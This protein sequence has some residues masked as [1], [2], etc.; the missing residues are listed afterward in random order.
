[1]LAAIR[2]A[3]SLLIPGTILT[4][5]IERET[6]QIVERYILQSKWGNA[7]MR[8]LWASSSLI[9]GQLMSTSELLE[10]MVAVGYEGSL[11]EWNKFRNEIVKN[12]RRASTTAERVALLRAYKA[13]MDAVEQA[14]G[15]AQKDIGEINKARLHEY[16]LMLIAEGAGPDGFW[17]S[18]K[19]EQIT[20]REIEAGRMS[21][22]DSLR[23]DT[24]RALSEMGVDPAPITRAR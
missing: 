11:R 17:D 18:Q 20:R 9:A 7:P 1:M 4:Q 23:K 22:N 3:S 21:P 19:M 15:L 14:P 2:R 10:Q 6:R 16:R 13:L 5:T 24:V 8:A 12:F